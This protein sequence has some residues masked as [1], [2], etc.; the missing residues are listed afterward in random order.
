MRVTGIDHVVFN[1]FDAERTLAWWTELVGAEPVR[2][3][4]WRRGEAPFLS[5]RISDTTILDLFEIERSGENVNHVAFVVEDVDL[6][7]LAASGRVTVESGPADLFGAQG[8]GRG[9]YLRDPD[10]N[11][12]EL[13]T[14][15]AA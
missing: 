14:Y 3:D 2:L 12:V 5:I 9:L 6:D 1:V 10:G 11:M 4:E 15:P 8:M 7:A 13:R